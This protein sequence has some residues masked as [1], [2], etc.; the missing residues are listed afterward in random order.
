MAS[1]ELTWKQFRYDYTKDFFS[2]PAYLTVSGQLSAENYSCALGY[3]YTFG[4]TFRAENSKTAHHLAEFWMIEPELSF[5]LHLSVNTLKCCF[6]VFINF[7]E[8]KSCAEDYL[9][10]YLKF[11]LQNNRDVIAIL[12]QHERESVKKTKGA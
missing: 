5:P 10:Y 1:G 3:V 8:L 12:D 9:K 7:E 6:R 4:P 11:I 2:K